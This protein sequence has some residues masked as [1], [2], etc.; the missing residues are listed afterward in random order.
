MGSEPFQSRPGRPG[1]FA[2]SID[3]PSA[4]GRKV[5]IPTGPPRLFR[6]ID[7]LRF[8]GPPPGFNPDRAAQAVSPGSQQPLQ[9]TSLWFQSRPGR[10]GCFAYVAMRLDNGTTEV[11]IPTGPPRLFR[12]QPHG[13]WTERS[14]VSIPTGP[15]RLFRRQTTFVVIALF[16]CFNPDRAAQAVSP[17]T[18]DACCSPFNG[19]SIPT[20]PP[21]LFRHYTFSAN[22]INWIRFNPDREGCK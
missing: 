10:P 2:D 18:E 3:Q 14:R 17:I 20:G 4:M 15:P 19:V 5:S 9:S 12:R 21:R 7:G 13:S 11:S 6:Q 16:V 8:A 22:R 1:C